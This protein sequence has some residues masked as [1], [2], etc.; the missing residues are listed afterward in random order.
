MAPAPALFGVGS[1]LVDTRAYFTAATMVIAVPT[2][3]KIFSWLATLYGGS[4]R[5]HTPLLFTLGFLALFTIGG[6]TGVVLAN[7][8]MD[9]ALHDTYYVVAHLGLN[10]TS[11]YYAFDY[12][13]ETMFLG[14]YLLFMLICNLFKIDVPRI[15]NILNIN[16]ENNNKPV[17]FNSKNI[18]CTNIQSAEN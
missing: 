15:N 11:Y 9:I 8:S 7:A 12:M 2:G 14:F 10:N 3:I 6:V 13:L 5:Y 1:Y 17:S 4:L 18:K 16:S